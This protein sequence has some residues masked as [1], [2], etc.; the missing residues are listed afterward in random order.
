MNQPTKLV[1]VEVTRQDW[2]DAHD[3]ARKLDTASFEE[4]ASNKYCCGCALA[5]AISR[6]MGEPWKVTANFTL[7]AYEG[8]NLQRYPLPPKVLALRIA[9]DTHEEVELPQSFVLEITDV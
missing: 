6:A 2:D 7:R 3:F 5:I 4:G 8:C 1:T 9:F